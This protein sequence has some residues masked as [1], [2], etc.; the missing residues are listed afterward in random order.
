M[1]SD[2]P[3]DSPLGRQ[4]TYVRPARVEEA[5]ALSDLALRSKAHW[6]YTAAFID[7]CRED[8]T[9]SED[10]I[11]RGFVFVLEEGERVIGFYTLWGAGDEAML[12]DLFVEPDHIGRGH[13][14]R[15]WDHGVEAARRLGYAVLTLHSDPHAE[16]F[17]LSMGAIRIGVVPPTVFPDRLLPLM[18]VTLRSS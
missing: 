10:D 6:G 16:D 2:Q 15:L 1:L 12:T 17:Y 18:H 3:Y 5:A 14:R 9:I 7:A 11:S 8:L 13:G 4:N